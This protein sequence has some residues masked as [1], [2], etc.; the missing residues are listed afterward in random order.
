LIYFNSEKI[1]DRLQKKFSRLVADYIAFGDVETW[2]FNIRSSQGVLLTVSY[3]LETARLSDFI[4]CLDRREVRQCNRDSLFRRNVR[5][6]II[7]AGLFSEDPQD[8]SYGLVGVSVSSRFV[9]RHL[10]R[11]CR[12]RIFALAQE[13]FD[14]IYDRVTR[15]VAFPRK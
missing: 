12:F 6:D 10:S 13:S 4:K 7:D 9:R 5:L 15:L 1:G 8:S 11:G 3:D 14:L 2:T